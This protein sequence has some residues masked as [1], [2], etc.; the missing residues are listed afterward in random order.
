MDGLP[1]DATS[2]FA[3]C[4]SACVC[5]GNDWD[6]VCG[7]DGITYVSPCLAGCTSSTGSGTNTVSHFRSFICVI[8]FSM[9]CVDILNNIF[10][11][12]A[13]ETIPFQDRCFRCSQST[14]KQVTEPC[15]VDITTHLK[16]LAK[17]SRQVEELNKQMCFNS[18]LR[19]T[20]MF[21]SVTL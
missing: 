12:T 17:N 11:I 2:V 5:P 9:L 13:D 4:N 15:C 14:T 8:Y 7:E 20:V 3:T 6:P 1:L 10:S 16:Y 21:H 19:T 18:A